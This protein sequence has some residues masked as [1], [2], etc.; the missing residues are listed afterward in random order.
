VGLKKIIFKTVKQIK[1]LRKY[2]QDMINLS[3]EGYDYDDELL[4]SV[5]E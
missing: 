4:V 5:N 3:I 2:C 1:K